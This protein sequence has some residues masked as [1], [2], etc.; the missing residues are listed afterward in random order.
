MYFLLE[1]QVFLGHATKLDLL[2]FD[3]HATLPAH[4][5]KVHQQW[6]QLD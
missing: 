6:K 4:I 2:L 3:G 5:L 1:K